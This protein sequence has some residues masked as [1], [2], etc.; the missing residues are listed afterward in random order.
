MSSIFNDDFQDFIRALNTCNVEYMLLGGYAVILYGYDRTTGDMDVW[1]NRTLDNYR[2]LQQAFLHFGMP[3][4]DMN[5][6]AFLDPETTDVFSF[7]LPP[8]SI[9]LLTNPKGVDFEDC[10]CRAVWLEH[11]RLPIRLICK[12]DLIHAKQAVG[13]PRDLDDIARLGTEIP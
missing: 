4:F 1:V 9:D 8:S 10:Y 2:R 7:G 6:E 12:A 5:Q 3:L 13:R 11:D